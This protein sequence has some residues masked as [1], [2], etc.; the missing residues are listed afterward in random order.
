MI[1]CLEV[2]KMFPTTQSLFLTL[3]K[4]FCLCMSYVFVGV[5]RGWLVSVLVFW[6]E[7]CMPGIVKF[8]GCVTIRIDA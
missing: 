6:I 7:L 1:A 4:L 3:C 8:T 2:W 5:G